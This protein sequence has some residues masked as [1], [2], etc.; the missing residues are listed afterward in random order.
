[1]DKLPNSD[2]K[3]SFPILRTSRTRLGDE[4]VISGE[5]GISNPG[6]FPAARESSPTC[7]R[8]LFDPFGLNLMFKRGLWTLHAAPVRTAEDGR[9]VRRL[10]RPGWRQIL[11]QAATGA[12]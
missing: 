9:R 7:S 4:V 6:S 10:G 1:M 8:L 3:A 11:A 5:R 2:W 12:V